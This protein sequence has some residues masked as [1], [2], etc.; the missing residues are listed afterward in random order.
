MKSL[1]R[2]ITILLTVLLMAAMAIPAAADY[3]T[4]GGTIT[5]NNAAVGANYTLYKVLDME[6]NPT[7]GA[8]RYK[9]TTDWATF[10]GTDQSTY[11][12]VSSGG[13]VTAKTG[14]T[15]SAAAT[16]AK[17]AKVYAEDTGNSVSKIASIKATTGTVTFT[18]LDCGYCLITSSAG[19]TC[20]LCT[21]LP[22]ETAAPTL[23]V[24]EKNALPSIKKEVDKTTARI[25]DTLT[26]TITITAKAGAKNY[27]VVDKLPDGLNV[28]NEAEVTVEYKKSGGTSSTTINDDVTVDVD[29]TERTITVNLST[30]CSSHTDIGTGDTFTITYTSSLNANAVVGTGGNTNT[31]ELAYGDTA[32][33][34]KQATATVY[35][36]SFDLVKTDSSNKVIDGAKFELYDSDE[37]TE[38]KVVKI[39]DGSYRVALS[40]ES[41][42]AIEAGNVT[43]SGL[44]NGTYYVKETEAPAGYI[45]AESLGT[46]TINNGNNSATVSGGAYSSGGVRVV[47]EQ[48]TELPKTGGIGTAVFYA[49]GITLMVCAGALLLRRRKD[50]TED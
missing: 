25:G 12:A 10:I 27:E 5:V 19:N 49:G 11:F 46:V 21:L 1:R 43:I 32:G 31:A 26:Y 16:V 4:S 23:S 40:G 9:T 42:V 48:G 35:T 50:G 8:Y 2:G 29:T 17:E 39:A 45:K 14:Y 3:Q 20:I 6:V 7:T 24:D 28:P 36:Y 30:Y 13:Y 38:I 47:N 37:T 44:A 15:D 41:G 33:L 18:D 34:L 22:G